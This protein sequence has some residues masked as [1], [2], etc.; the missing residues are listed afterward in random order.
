MLVCCYVENIGLERLDHNRVGTMDYHV[1]AE[2]IVHQG[3]RLLVGCDGEGYIQLAIGTDPIAMPEHDF[4]RLL[5]M[6]HYRIVP[7]DLHLDQLATLRDRDQ[8]AD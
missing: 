1:I 7:A 8:V 3:R 4:V 2:S 5:A 6:R